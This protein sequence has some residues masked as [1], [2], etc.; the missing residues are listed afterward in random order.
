VEEP[1]QPGNA[2]ALAALARSVDCPLA[3]GERL[4]TLRDFADLADL[5]AVAIIQPDLSHCGGLSG[6]RRIAAIA[7]AAQMA[8][9]P[10]NPMGPVAG[11]VALH[12]DTATPNFLIQEEAVG[13]VPWFD[14]I[15]SHPLQL[16]DGCWE[17]PQGVGFGVEIDEAVAAR[18]PFAPEIVPATEAVLKDGT[19]A[20]W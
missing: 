19:I 13:L 4:F 20:Y 7:E 11:A 8:V 3:T 5:R 16:V 15:C 2:A 1:I 18:Y 12:F 14:E 6:G 17:V 10:H 9:A